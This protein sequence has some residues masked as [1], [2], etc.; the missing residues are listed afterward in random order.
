MRTDFAVSGAVLFFPVSK[1]FTMITK[2]FGFLIG[3]FGPTSSG[4][5]G[6]KGQPGT[7]YFKWKPCY[8]LFVDEEQGG[9]MERARSSRGC[10]GQGT[11]GRDP[12][13]TCQLS[14]ADVKTPVASGKPRW[15]VSYVVHVRNFPTVIDFSCQDQGEHVHLA[16]T[17]PARSSGAFF[18]PF[19]FLLNNYWGS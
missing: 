1:R 3:F 16:W 4:A 6:N 11:A 17:A 9:W 5:L 15:F 2:V 18:Y 14:C 8:G 12:Q 13:R 10:R 7:S 19:S